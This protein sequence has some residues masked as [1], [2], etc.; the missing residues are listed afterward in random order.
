MNMNK[1]PLKNVLYINLNDNSFEID[2]RPELFRDFLG[3]TGVA[4]HLLS[5]ETGSD[6]APLGKENVIILA[7][8]PLVGAFPMASKAVSMFKS[9]LT[10]NLGESHA[11]GRASTS[12][13]SAGL[14][15]I[16]IK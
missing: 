1:D 8:G 16:V 2:K 4:A 15:A 11:G 9:P 7:T 13:R 6:T 3:G 14:G 10:G 12:I 5:E